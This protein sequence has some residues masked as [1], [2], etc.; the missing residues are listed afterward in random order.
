MYYLSKGLSE[1]GRA[2]LGKFL[3][4]AFAICCIGGAL[5]GGNM[6]QANQAAQQI[7]SIFPFF[8]E[9]GVV[10]GIIMAVVVG[11]V[12]IGGIKSIASN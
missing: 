12:I 8:A 6:F 5:G 7:S 1:R 10:F 4:V 3:A 11:V 2:G 9:N